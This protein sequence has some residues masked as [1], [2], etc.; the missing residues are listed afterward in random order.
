M[1]YC[2]FVIPGGEFVIRHELEE[3]QVP[4]SDGPL[5]LVPGARSRLQARPRV[6]GGDSG[7]TPGDLNT[8]N[9]TTENQVLCPR[10]ILITASP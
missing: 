3:L 1:T 10:Q 8:D 6:G 9:F 5:E 4:L 2:T 7:Q